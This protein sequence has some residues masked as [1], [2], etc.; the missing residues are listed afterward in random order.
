MDPLNELISDAIN[1]AIN[2]AVRNG[3]TNTSIDLLKLTCGE[4]VPVPP[5][6]LKKLGN[7]GFVLSFSVRCHRHTSNCDYGCCCPSTPTDMKINWHTPTHAT[8]RQY[9]NATL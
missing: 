5:E 1:L 7:A 4:S 3:L 6:I 9:K 2:A 8:A